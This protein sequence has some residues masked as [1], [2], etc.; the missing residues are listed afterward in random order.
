MIV[1]H[2]EIGITR[3]RPTG[4]GLDRCKIGALVLGALVLVGYPL[5]NLLRS[6]FGGPSGPAGVRQAIATR[7]VGVALLHTVAVSA[8]ATVLATVLGV[9]MALLVARSDLPFRRL[10]AFAWVAPLVIPA[11]VTGLA[12]LDAYTRA[13][14]TDELAHLSANWLSGAVGVALLL[15]LQGAPIAYLVVLAALGSGRTGELEDAARSAGRTPVGVLWDVTLPLVRSAIVG[16]MLLVFVSSASDF[17]IPAVL[18]IPAGFSTVTT[19]I[20]SD[21]SFAGGA[22]A[23]SSAASLSALLGVLA[24]ILVLA[25][26][27][28]ARIRSGPGRGGG[29]ANSARP[30]ISL[31]RL[32]TP[33]AMICALFL[34]ATTVLPLLALIVTSVSP[35]FRLTP[36]PGDWVGAAYAAALSGD[37]IAA[38][39]RSVLL[40]GSAAVIVAIG[41][42]AVALLLR[43]N[44]RLANASATLL[45]LP[46]AL[47]GS[48]VAVAVLIAWQRWLYGSL[49]I[50]LL[51]YVA[52]FAVIGIRTSVATLGGLSDDLVEAARVS[53]ATARHAMLDVIRPAMSPGIVTSFAIVFLFGIHELT[54][55]SL[56]YGPST[57]TFAVQVLAAEEA[58]EL[59]LTAALAVLVTAITVL[60]AGAALLVRSSRRIVATEAGVE[61]PAWQR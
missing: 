13:G 37:N 48:V 50:I 7:P 44:G 21:L 57:K 23:I 22:N 40:A 24:V 31:G 35:A 28:L 43:R 60:V 46:F 61:V 59:A 55:S 19:L 52:R 15:G 1:P 2:G 5:A 56:L 58:G 8:S 51:A 14:L 3:Q 49:L 16:S 4:R 27:R 17:G 45:A 26:N 11:Y 32:R 20:Y 29:Q 30:L 18:A 53:G 6:I 39:G 33:V 47:P 10:F 36:W 42:A 9:A 25:T 34:L 38:L 12:W 54:M 41:G